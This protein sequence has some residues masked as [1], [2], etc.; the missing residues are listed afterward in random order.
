MTM[1]RRL[2]YLLVSALALAAGVWGFTIQVREGV[3]PRDLAVDALEYPLHVDARPAHSLAELRFVV[4]DFPPGTEL[5]LVGPDGTS[6]PIVLERNF[7]PTYYGLTLFSGLYFWVVAALVFALRAG[8]PGVPAFYWITLLYGLA[9]LIGGVFHHSDVA[10]PRIVLPLL[11]LAC[12]AFLPPALVHLAMTFPRRLAV[13]DRRPWLMPALWA[14]SG[15]VLVWQS[16]GFLR[17]FVAPSAE[18][19]AG[20]ATPQ[21]AADLVMVALVLTGLVVLTIS[22]MRSERVRQKKQVRWLLWGFAFGAAPYVFLRTLPQLMGIDAPLPP[23]LDRIFE[24][25]I[26][27]AF[28]FAVVYHQ[29]LDIDIII[30]RSLIYGALASGLVLLVPV[31]IVALCRRYLDGSMLW[32]PLAAA[33]CGLVAGLLFAPLRRMIGA[34]VDRIFFKLDRDLDAALADLAGRLESAAT[35][36]ELVRHVD[37]AVGRVLAPRRHAVI[38]GD[39]EAFVRAGDVSADETAG[40]FST[41]RDEL[42]EENEAVA[43]PGS[44]GVPEIEIETY[45]RGL[46]D[47]GIVLLQPLCDEQRV[48]GL[49]LVGRRATERR[50]IEADVDWLADCA[51]L[52]VKALQ[53][54]EFLRV[55]ASESLR[56]RQADELNRLKTDF[57]SQVSHDLRTPLASIDWSVQNL[58]DGLA[59]DLN[60]KQRS[61]MVSVRESVDHLGNL[62][63][64][65]LEISR[66]EKSVIEL[67]LCELSLRPLLESVIRTAA[68]LAERRDVALVLDVEPAEL[69]VTAH[70]AKLRE[71]VL[72]LVDNAIKYSPPGSAVEL[73]GAPTSDG[74]IEICV[75]DHGPGLGDL[76]RPF[77]RFVQGEASPH[78][79]QQGFGLGLYIVREYLHLMGG[80]VTGDDHPDGGARFR[81]LLPA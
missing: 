18:R 29:F 56:R 62:V 55:A 35:L 69:G 58:V 54:L 81:C 57:L 47:L 77:D 8:Q 2:S 5:D 26:P 30:R 52:V 34:W 41:G 72:N 46:S 3:L 45:P 68:P 44:T 65:L 48:A 42:V 74:R 4:Q 16:F 9:V 39:G 1:D 80:E 79:A 12:L 6:R 32:I 50:Y 38:V 7:S 33:A 36:D 21:L 43:V 11:Q 37:E 14:L 25:A 49:I 51:D 20:L 59:G 23:F 75:R 73:S 31:P 22:G 13:I 15:G 60:E 10:Q 24:L 17:Y 40:I 64:N 66:L 61:Y 76:S 53:R 63:N 71:S 67:P 78:V 70:D 27:T 19:F 28:V